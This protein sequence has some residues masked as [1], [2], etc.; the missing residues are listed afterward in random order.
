MLVDVHAHLEH[1][2]YEGKL[3][4]VIERC[5]KSNVVRIVTSGVNRESNRRSL[6]IAKKYSDVVRVSL[7]LYPLD[8]LNK[9]IKA[10]GFV[11]DIERFDVDEEIEFIKKNKNK[12]VGVG[13]VGLDFNFRDCEKEEQK[14]NFLKV[15]EL[16]ERIKKPVVVHS[17]KAEKEVVEILECSNL[18]KVVMH[19]FSGSFKLVKKGMDEGWNF[20]IPC[21]ILK[22][23]HFQGLVE[24]VPLNQ[25]L[26]E[27]DSPYAPPLGKE[28]NEPSNVKFIV[29]KI[30][31]I[32]KMNVKEVENNIFMNYQRLF[33]G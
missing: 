13:E 21:S 23:L 12:I 17:R 33:E 20:S 22:S 9:E 29:E 32:K 26:T 7:G 27:T 24:L 2:R 30:S 4:E 18:K 1:F 15:I 28:I 6:E 25:L 31:E 14:K 11:R 3:D 10:D 19:F 16:C 8:A 5:R